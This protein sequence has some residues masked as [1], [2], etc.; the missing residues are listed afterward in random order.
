MWSDRLYDG[1]HEPLV[2]P[3]L[4]DAVQ[5]ALDHRYAS[6]HRKVKH[7]FAFAGLIACG[8]CGCSLV[9]ELKKG[10]YVYHHCTGYKGK[11]PEPY[12]REE[13][14]S[15]KFA[16]FLDRLHFDDEIL[17]W[18][19]TALRAS[20]AEE[21]AFREESIARLRADSETLQ[22]RIDQMYLDKLDGLIDA[23]FFERKSQEW[24]EQ[25]GRAQR[26]IQAHQSADQ[27][28]LE[29][30]AKL[31]ELAQQAGSLFRKQE[32]REQRQLLNFLFSKCSWR[33]G[34][35]SAEYRKPFDLLASAV[36]EDHAQSPSIGASERKTAIWLGREDSN[37]RMSDPKSDALPL[38]DAPAWPTKRVEYT[39]GNGC[40]MG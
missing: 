15:E 28:Y 31:L 38:G 25:Q 29:Q 39:R 10:K 30:G 24:R 35:L 8:H 12:T 22:R 37:L 14:L 1:K 11:C 5:D 26:A 7:D 9:A 21:S 40:R 16:D 20:H 32:P 4:W 27:G 17:A 18:V 3:D 19:T 13:V 6:R 33:E 36:V 2:S 23:E 34:R